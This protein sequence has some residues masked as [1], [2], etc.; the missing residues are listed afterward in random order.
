MK[1]NSK[2]KAETKFIAKAINERHDPQ[3][4]VKGSHNYCPK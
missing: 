4:S 2:S 3:N 1:W